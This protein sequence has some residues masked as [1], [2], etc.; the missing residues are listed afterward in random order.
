[1]ADDN[2]RAG[3]RQRAPS[4]PR[5]DKLDRARQRRL[6]VL[7]ATAERERRVQQQSET[8]QFVAALNREVRL[9]HER[10]RRVEA[11]KCR[12]AEVQRRKNSRRDASLQ[13]LNEVESR[14]SLA[15]TGRDGK[16]Q[17]GGPLTVSNGSLKSPNGSAHGLGAAPRPLLNLNEYAGS[18]PVY[19]REAAEP[20]VSGSSP[21]R[22]GALPMLFPALP[23]SPTRDDAARERTTDAQKR[24]YLV[25]AAQKL[26][27]LQ[28]R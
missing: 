24:L 18:R 16:V 28:P 12:N 1:M 3:D 17:G 27:A 9:I 13:A 8:Q 5:D 26:L 23:R 4:S 10:D 2:Q 15:R 14:L 22:P 19:V 7:A 25:Q 20:A 11:S 6:A 21:R